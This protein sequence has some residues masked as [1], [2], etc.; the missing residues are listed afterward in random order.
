MMDGM[1]HLDEGG[2]G[3]WEGSD[4]LLDELDGWDMR[5]EGE[6][7]AESSAPPSLGDDGRQITETF[8]ADEIALTVRADAESAPL[9][10]EIPKPSS[11]DEHTSPS[12]VDATED[13]PDQKRVDLGPASDAP[14]SESI[15]TPTREGAPADAPTA[16]EDT[17]RR[18]QM[19]RQG[20]MRAL[21]SMSEEMMGGLIATDVWK[22]DTAMAIAGINTQPKAVALFNRVSEMITRT[23]VGAEN[24][25]ATGI[26]QYMIQTEDGLFVFV[27]ELGDGYRW[28]ML[29]DGSKAPVGLMLSVIIPE[30]LANIRAALAA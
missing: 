27:V 3:E 30:T 14:Y 19:D 18:S 22:T 7:G 10:E 5:D 23:M 12:Q 25:F 4:V 16:Q 17:P 24:S 13:A 2:L 9:L 26:A 11:L 1:R 15:S 6:P 28:G 29:V 21:E 20:L 8:E